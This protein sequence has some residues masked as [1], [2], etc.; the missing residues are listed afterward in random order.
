M[1]GAG[2]GVSQ[3]WNS[4]HYEPECILGVI[5][6]NVVVKDMILFHQLITLHTCNTCGICVCMHDEKA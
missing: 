4:T 1:R 2:G 3:G 5:V 6:P